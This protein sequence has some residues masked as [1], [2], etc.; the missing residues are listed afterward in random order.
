MPK[1]D[2]KTPIFSLV[3][4]IYL[5][6]ITINSRINKG[7]SDINVPATTKS[8]YFIAL[9]D[10][11]KPP[12][13]AIATVPAN[14]KLYFLSCNILFQEKIFFEAIEKTNKTIAK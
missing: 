7:S 4:G 5:Q 2:K 1:T 11:Q 13:V 14:F 6:N 12:Y 10:N 8:Q 9:N 3:T